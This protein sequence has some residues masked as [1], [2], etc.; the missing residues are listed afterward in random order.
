MWLLNSRPEEIKD[1]KGPEAGLIRAVNEC[2]QMLCKVGWDVKKELVIQIHL[3]A[4]KPCTNHPKLDL[5]HDSV[6]PSPLS[7]PLACSIHAHGMRAPGCWLVRSGC[8]THRNVGDRASWWFW[9]WCLQPEGPDSNPA[10]PF[11]GCV[12]L[13]DNTSPQ[14]FCFFFHKVGAKWDK[15]SALKDAQLILP[16]ISLVITPK[17]KK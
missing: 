4:G 6:S 11:P 1:H 15:T 9:A 7:S 14:C 10:V 3:R 16:I 17:L 5:C 13:A 12:S 2:L 8:G